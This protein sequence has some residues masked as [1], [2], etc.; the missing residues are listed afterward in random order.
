MSTA[1]WIH[2]SD[3]HLRTETEFDS[4]IVR[5]ELLK[6]I[7]KCNGDYGLEPDFI[8][9][10]G[11]IAF[12]GQPEEYA[13]ASEFFDKTLSQLKLPRDRL[14]LVPGNHDVDR[15]AIKGILSTK[16]AEILNDHDIV[17]E[18]FS[19]RE[20][21]SQVFGRLHNF[22]NFV[23]NYF[24]DKHP[25]WNLDHPY[26]V[27]PLILSG[28]TL[29]I[30]GLTTAFASS[31]GDKKGMLLL[32]EPQVRWA[33]DELNH[34]EK[35]LKGMGKRIDFRIGLYHHPIEWLQSFDEKLVRPLLF[36]N[37]DVLL[38]G[39][40]HETHLEL[41]GKPKSNAVQIAAGAIYDKWKEP[42]I[43]FSYN[44]G[45]LDFT[46]KVGTVFLR[47]YSPLDGG[48]WHEDH[49]NYKGTQR[50]Q[51]SWKWNEGIQLRPRLV[52]VVED[53]SQWRDFLVGDIDTKDANDGSEIIEVLAESDFTTSLQRISR[54]HIDLL[55]T[56]I[57]LGD[58]AGLGRTG[59]DLVKL[60][61][62]IPVIVLT[63]TS[64]FLAEHVEIA[65]R[66]LQVMKKRAYDPNQLNSMIRQALKLPR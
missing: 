44:Y 38:H 57:D 50:G 63:G 40:L 18:F 64:S 36:D 9:V 6:D 14:F 23:Q 12:S 58:D 13:M 52:L 20:E 33:F 16:V 28:H 8:V 39:H 62:D 37:F 65:G 61:P 30:V 17:T 25:Y 54:D 34:L 49:E 56:D 53:Q 29:A 11:D 2:L 45:R 24:G 47:T 48:F 26:Y 3:L 27:H 4:S 31:Q 5:N 51:W 32:G 15:K 41:T 60:V 59:L 42:N 21:L 19:N 1:T 7:Y 43:P 35:K 55:I 22:A 66:E 10:S 46:N